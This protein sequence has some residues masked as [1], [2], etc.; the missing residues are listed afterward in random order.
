[1]ATTTY[2]QL[3][4]PAYNSSAWDV[5]LN[6]N[7]TILDNAFGGTTSV[8]LVASNVTLTSTQ[9]QAM[10]LRFTGAISANITIYIPSG[11]YGRWTVTNATTG[12]FTL[13]IASAAGGTT[14]AIAQGYSSLI[15]C[16]STGV[17]ASDSGILQGGVLPTL[18][19]TGNTTLGTNSSNTLTV[20]AT[21][22]FAAP[23]TYNATVT[24]NGA[25]TTA[26]VVTDNIIEPITVSATS[27]TGTI[28]YDVLTQSV[29]YYTQNATGNFTINIRGSSSTTLNSVMST[30]QAIT[31]VFMITNGSTAYYNSA[32]TIDGASVT[33]KWQ[34]GA[35]P[36]AGNASSVDI[37]TYTIVKTGSAAYTVFATQIKY[38]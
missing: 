38:A 5:P 35:T 37:Y 7:E 17:F 12:A 24:F 30:G 28:N 29:V 26:A 34:G 1:M 16:D 23:T 14:Y 33:P 4:Q 22:T 2:L 13:T 3:N 32:V 36:T 18:S 31:V 21:S 8:S 15:C 25:A 10:Q 6:A 20:N 19:V 11:Y 27:A 9:L